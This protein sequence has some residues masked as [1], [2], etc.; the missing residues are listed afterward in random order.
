MTIRSS[1]GRSGS[2]LELAKLISVKLGA[3][4]W[5]VDP[6]TAMAT[7]GRGTLDCKANCYR[8]VCLWGEIDVFAGDLRRA[9]VVEGEEVYFVGY[10]GF[11]DHLRRL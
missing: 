4:L 7:D 1:G 5:N 8:I 10:H 6:Q 11:R 3:L 2:L 9:I